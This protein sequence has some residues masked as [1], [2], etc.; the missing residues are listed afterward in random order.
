MRVGGGP[1]IVEDGLVLHLDAANQRSFRGEPTEN[2]RTTNTNGEYDRL[3]YNGGEYNWY[4]IQTSGQYIG[5]HKITATKTSQNNNLI[6]ILSGIASDPNKTYTVSVE[7]VS[8]YNNLDFKVTGFQGK[9]DITRI[10]N[11]NRY[12][13]TFTNN[14]GGNLNLYLRAPSLSS[15]Q[16][17]TNGVIYFRNIQWEEKPYPTPFVNGTRGTTFETGGGWADLS[18]NSNHGELVNGVQYDT[19]NRGTLV[20]DGVNDYISFSDAPNLLFLDRTP[21][22]L[23]A[24]FYITTNP[25]GSQTYTGIFNRENTFEGSRDGYNLWLHPTSNNE[26]TL[27]SER[28]QSGENRNV[29]HTVTNSILNSWQ[30][31]CVTYNGVGNTLR[32]Y[33]NTDLVSSNSNANGKLVN[34]SKTLEIG[35]RNS[36][37]YFNGRLAEQKIYN[38]ALS[39]EE[40]KQ[41]FNAT[42]W[43]FGL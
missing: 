15:N 21:Y 25:Y 5:W 3:N 31:I 35:K 43:R 34:D 16:T 11:S 26:M 39:H 30:H 19:S 37:G 17:I 28:Y 32:M 9:A 8:P 4:G 24:W 33:Y 14:Q 38:R 23:E 18:A 20:F 27:T 29:S 6:M 22:T 7:F 41:N 2:L 13:T 1:N 12:Y 42:K 10:G 36:D 40:I